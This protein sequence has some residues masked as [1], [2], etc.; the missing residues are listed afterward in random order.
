M[1]EHEN[2]NATTDAE[3]IVEA[4]NWLKPMA[5]ALLDKKSLTDTAWVI[6]WPEDRHHTTRYYSAGELP[7]RNINHATRFS[8]K[9]DAER[10]AKDYGKSGYH[11]WTVSEYTF[12]EG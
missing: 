10:T 7:V 12:D 8:R 6:E 1:T 5:E 11:G 3:L 4:V 2:K 9:E